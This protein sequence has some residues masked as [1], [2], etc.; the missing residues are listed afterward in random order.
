MTV[1]NYNYVGKFD[2]ILITSSRGI[3]LKV[4]DEIL[5]FLNFTEIWFIYSLCIKL[6]SICKPP[7]RPCGDQ[8]RFRCNAADKN[9][10]V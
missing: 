6:V 5:W 10:I 2:R 7:A 9:K 3:T 1:T 4:L 8:V